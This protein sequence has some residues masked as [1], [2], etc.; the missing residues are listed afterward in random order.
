[1]IY[2]FNH[3]TP[4]KDDEHSQAEEQIP[5]YHGNFASKSIVALCRYSSINFG[6]NYGAVW[7]PV[8]TDASTNWDVGM[9]SGTWRVVVPKARVT[10]ILLSNGL[11]AMDR[12]T[13]LAG[14][15]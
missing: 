3:S 14:D 7:T 10:P 9:V 6:N 13:L 8:D 1:M 15:A 12:P 11:Q 5:S 4:P 2:E